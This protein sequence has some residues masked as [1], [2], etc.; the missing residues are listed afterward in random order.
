M[1]CCKQESILRDFLASHEG[2]VRDDA[3][4]LEAAKRYLACPVDPGDQEE[5]LANLNLSIGRILSLKNSP[6]EAIPYF[7]KSA[8]YNTK[9]KTSPLTYVYL[10][11]AYE[12]GPYDKLEAAYQ[13]RF[14]G[15]DES[16]ES[17]LALENILQI[18][19]RIIDAY[20]RAVALAHFESAE[21]LSETARATVRALSNRRPTDW[22]D[23]L[24]ELYK[25]RHDKSDAGLKGLI[26]TVLSQPLPP[27]PTPITSLPPRKKET[28]TH[29]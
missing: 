28:A 29:D 25:F 16:D 9:V 20:A 15:K 19:D 26:G 8:S 5:A 13:V 1:Q 3:K 7:I 23:R 18:V 10:A 22:M 2:D 27:E 14:S 21:Q 11:E 6:S 4:A 17:L 12:Q 24:R